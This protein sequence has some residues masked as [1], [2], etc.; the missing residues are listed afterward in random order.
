MSYLV[1]DFQ[2]IRPEGRVVLKTMDPLN[3]MD[4][5]PVNFDLPV[6]GKKYN[7]G[8]TLSTIMTQL[9]RRD[10]FETRSQF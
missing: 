9:H 6:A 8:S 2:T 7:Q 5:I 3:P 1:Y 10:D 4:L